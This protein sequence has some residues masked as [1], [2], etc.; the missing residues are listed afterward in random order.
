M[1][2]ELKIKDEKQSTWEKVCLFIITKGVYLILFTPLVLS[3]NF[4]FPFV[5][6]KS[7]YFMG[8]VEV[9][10]L[11]YLFLVF[12]CSKYRPKFNLLS[13]SLTLFSFVL[14]LSTLFGADPSYSFWSKYER[15]TGLLMW[16]HLLAFFI[17]TSSVLK[18]KDWH[19]VFAVSLFVAVLIGLISLLAK[20]GASSFVEMSRQG[21]TLGNSSFMATYLLFNAFFA[22][23]LFSQNKFK[24][25]SLSC[26]SLILLA[27]FFSGGRASTLSFLG[28]I[29]LLSLLW[30][31]FTRQGKQ[32]L[33][34][35]ILLAVFSLGA[36][37]AMFSVL[38]PDS[39]VRQKFMENAGKD[40]LM[41]WGMA[42]Q[43]LM[44]RPLLGWGPENFDLVFSKH[45]EPCIFL[46]EYGRDIWF[47]RTHNI[48]FDTLAASGIIGLLS[49]LGIFISVFYALW[50]KYF[51]DKLDFWTVGIF[52]TLLV[53]Y[54][55]QNLTVFDMVSSYMMLFLVLGFLSYMLAPS[56]TTDTVFKSPRPLLIAG[57]SALFLL[58]FIKFVVQPIIADSYIIY[59]LGAPTSTER[60][61]LAKKALNAS[62]LGRYQ[63]REI[64]ADN[65][66]K[67]INSGE[68]GK[69]SEEDIKKELAFVAGELKKSTEEA[70]LNYRNYLKLGEF[71]NF[72]SRFD[73]TKLVEAEKILDKTIELSPTNQQGYWTLAQT[74]AYQKDFVAA[75]AL[76]EQALQ[77]NEKVIHSHKVII[78]ISQMMGNY[79]MAKEKAIAA[80]PF[81][82]EMTRTAPSVSVYLDLIQIAQAAE[83]YNLAKEKAEE[84][85]SFNPD[86]EPHFKE[87]IEE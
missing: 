5:G 26:F 7:L 36:L 42:W 55:I 83:D 64:F 24:I 30:L 34:G 48:V 58:S 81:A 68:Q 43:G 17:V 87:F 72:Y 80:I 63:L 9:I 18:K 60:I 23:Y 35:V 11:A 16:F 62:P 13:V 25:Y 28:G 77:L 12:S 49:Y 8:F 1:N 45:F 57:L 4:F 75:F 65:T 59:A 84:A 46:P 50:R 14:I 51:K 56:R 22:I 70:P 54:F 15:M 47:D 85:I 74:K 86:W 29:F 2:P 61:D 40:R 82:E 38:Q 44:E 32:K 10:F 39:F 79:D 41:V 73:S 6:P 76:A 37:G 19:K 27:L 21:S 69:M 31:A 67:Y 78:Q 3:G 66:T 71:Y 33:V 52:S 20:A 53:A